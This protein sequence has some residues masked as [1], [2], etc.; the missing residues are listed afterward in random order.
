MLQASAPVETLSP[1]KG[2]FEGAVSD[3]MTRRGCCGKAEVCHLPARL[4]CTGERGLRSPPGILWARRWDSTS[5]RNPSQGI[6]A[7]LPG[8]V[9]PCPL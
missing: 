4:E 3:G 8:A 2:S 7:G 9:C 6:L 1:V 5:S